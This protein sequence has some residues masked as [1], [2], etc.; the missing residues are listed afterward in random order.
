MG[1][2][3]VRFAARS[4]AVL[5][6]VLGVVSSLPV[7]ASEPPALSG[8]VRDTVGNLLGG[9]EILFVDPDRASRPVAVTRSGRD[10]RFALQDLLPGAYQVAAVKEGYL[11]FVGGVDTLV[12]TTLDLVLRPALAVDADEIPRDASWALRLPRRSVLREVAAEPVQA[13]RDLESE[14][15]SARLAEPVRVQVDQMFSVGAEG[16]NN[17]TQSAGVDAGRTRMLLASSMGGR[18]RINFEGWR[19]R[20]A[21]DRPTD[22]SD[23]GASRRASSVNVNLSYETGPDAEL[24]VNAFFNQTDY[25]LATTPAGRGRSTRRTGSPSRW[26]TTTPR[27]WVPEQKPHRRSR[28]RMPAGEWRLVRSARKV[29][30]RASSTTGMK[31]GWHSVP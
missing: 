15:L 23:G 16:S 9:V 17:G 4:A 21:A 26:T 8:Q 6:L 19:E 31:C 30:T 20:V 27:S 7:R 14:G 3:R 11:T 29:P 22:V 10:G 13:P 12:Q 28:S 18:G 5:I 2:A 25:E 24:A 1:T